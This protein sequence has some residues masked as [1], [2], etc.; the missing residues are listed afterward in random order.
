M[1]LS[2]ILI[3]TSSDGASVIPPLIPPIVILS[4]VVPVVAPDL[5]MV[6]VVLCVKS[7]SVGALAWCEKEHTGP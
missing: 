2:P 6:P 3:T 4:P 5:T 1:H 7:R